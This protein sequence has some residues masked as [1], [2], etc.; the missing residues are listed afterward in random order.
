M[1]RT[2]ALVTA[3][4]LL[5][6]GL[7]G[8]ALAQAGLTPI[9]QIQGDSDMSPLEGQLVT[10]QG[11]VT[12]AFPHGLSRLDGFFLQDATGDAEPA[13]SEGIFVY[14]N[15]KNVTATVGATLTVTG[16][17]KEYYGLTEIVLDAAGLVA[18]ET[19]AVPPTPIDDVPCDEAEAAASLE[20]FEGMR[21]TLPDLTVVGATDHNG[22]AYGVPA[23]LGRFALY[24]GHQLG[25]R[26]GLLAPTGWLTLDHGQKVMAP[27]GVLAF[28]FGAFKLAVPED[29]V[30]ETMPSAVSPP[31]PPVPASADEITVATYNVQD[32]FES[33]V[34]P[35]AYSVAI[36]RRAR[37]IAEG[38]G[39]PDLV[40][41]QEVENLAVI[42]DLAT[43][44][45][46]AA[47]DYDPVLMDGPDVRGI[48]VGL[49]FNRRRLVLAGEP[50]A[51]QACTA[52]GSLGGPG[53]SCTLPNGGQGWH[54]FSRPPLVVNLFVRGTG[55]RLVVIVNHFKSKSGGDAETR[56]Y[57]VEQ[58]EFVRGLAVAARETYP[59]AK[60]VV[61]GD[62]NDFEDSAMIQALTAGGNLASL[63][64]APTGLHDYSYNFGGVRQILDHILMSPGQQYRD[65]HAVHVNTDFAAPAPD[66]LDTDVQHVAD[67]DPLYARLVVSH[68]LYLP[69]TLDLSYRGGG[70]N[71]FTPA[72][73]TPTAKLTP[74]PTLTRH[75][76]A[77]RAHDDPH[78]VTT[79]IANSQRRRP[80]P[81]PAAHR[82]HPL[83][84]RHRPQRAR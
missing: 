50:Q 54:L 46:L 64:P 26:L 55:T 25:C 65:F 7:T 34:S 69:H 33:G 71:D 57:R 66:N 44:P 17:V 42:E 49:L 56:P 32:L 67:H 14:D 5:P 13:T 62:L 40:G 84:R 10:T 47:A 75:A 81:I 8:P 1:L 18:A 51:R 72:P 11:V 58:A 35:A 19:V 3:G 41:L 70:G 38:L 76:H 12:A 9:H 29:A 30:L 37:S 27:V 74:E 77:A 73:P 52:R 16:T 21:V 60:I 20:A 80:T 68:T 39:L 61:L 53:T 15:G 48:D 4:L 24:R 83:R 63:W 31:P 82:R 2:R 23:S 45:L 6:L 43:H 78:P 79:T 59:S 22:E 28:T 36:A